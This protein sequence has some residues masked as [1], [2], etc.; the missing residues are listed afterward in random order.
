M[1]D[2]RKY[3]DTLLATKKVLVISKSYCPY[4]H[5]AKAALESFNFLPGALEWIEID[6]RD[7]MAAIQDYMAELSGGR[8][9]PRVFING[10]FLGGGDDTAAAKADGSLEKKLAEVGA[11]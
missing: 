8:T 1:L 7:D 3:I 4:C 11:I 10:E 5:K 9:V 2:I 6:G